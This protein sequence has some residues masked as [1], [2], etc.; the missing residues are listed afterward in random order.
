[1]MPCFLAALDMPHL[2]YC[3]YASHVA[4]LALLLKVPSVVNIMYVCNVNTTQLMLMMIK[5]TFTRDGT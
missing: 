4:I 1:M 2:Y 5:E 3:K